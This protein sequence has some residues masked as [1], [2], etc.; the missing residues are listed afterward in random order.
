VSETFAVQPCVIK[1]TRLDA[2]VIS[3]L[4]K[5]YKVEPAFYL[6]VSE[7]QILTRKM[8]LDDYRSL[9]NPVFTGFSTVYHAEHN[10]TGDTVAIKLCKKPYVVNPQW[11]I[12]A[13][14]AVMPKWRPRLREHFKHEGMEALVFDYVEGRI[15][16]EVLSD[17]SR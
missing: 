1:C 2:I 11:E 7:G 8:G 3:F 4:V 9:A 14:K 12:K 10:E 15:L 17:N 13:N 16:K 6:L 5:V